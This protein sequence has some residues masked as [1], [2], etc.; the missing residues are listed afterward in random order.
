MLKKKKKG[1]GR[2]N[3]AT[4]PI[5]DLGTIKKQLSN[6]TQACTCKLTCFNIRL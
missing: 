3:V 2:G 5:S 1:E 6:T 4:Q